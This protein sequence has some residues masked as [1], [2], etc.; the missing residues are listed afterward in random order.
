MKFRIVLATLFALTLLCSSAAVAKNAK[1]VKVDVCHQEGNGGY[2]IVNV[3]INAVQAHLGHG[4]WVVSEEVCDGILDNDC[5]G[6]DDPDEIDDDLDSLTECDGDCD[7]GDD[8][9]FPGAEEVCGDGLD[10]NCDG[11]VDEDCGHCPCFTYDDLVPFWPGMAPEW[12]YCEEGLGDYGDYWGY[13]YSWT[14]EW[15]N[16]WDKNY[17]CYLYATFDDYQDP[18]NDLYIFEYQIINQNEYLACDAI[19]TDFFLDAG[20]E[21]YEYVY[22]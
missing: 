4:D 12:A 20:L 15:G 10:N 1:N 11:Q 18:A 16:E 8:T 17:N 14:Q 2:H 5:D 7:D 3:S 9:I 22:P 13:L 6:V 21:C 19:L